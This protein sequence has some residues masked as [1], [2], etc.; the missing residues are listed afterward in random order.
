MGPHDDMHAAIASL[1]FAGLGDVSWEHALDKVLAVTGFTGAALWSLRSVTKFAAGRTIWH[2]LDTSGKDDYIEHYANIDPHVRLLRD[3]IANRIRYD[4]LALPE[5]DMNRHEYY[6]WHEHTSGGLRYRIGG[7]T[8]PGTPYFGSFTLHRPKSRGHATKSEIDRFRL[9]FDH[10]E[11]ALE[12]EYRLD[13]QRGIVAG[14]A[15]AAAADS[16]C[17]GLDHRGQLIF[18]NAMAS[19]L[20]RGAFTLGPEGIAARIGE[21]NR[22][23][24]AL[25]GAC[26][27]VACGAGVRPGGA[28]RLSRPRRSDLFVTVAPVPRDG[29]NPRW[30]GASVLILIVDPNIARAPDEAV[31]RQLFGLTPAEAA[32]AAQLAIGLSLREAASAR[33]IAYSTARSYLE[34]IFHRTGTR[35][36]AELTRV[37]L[38]L[39]KAS[40]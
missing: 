35:R 25:I 28:M 21:Q 1:H 11:R 27:D 3:P 26:L 34:Q 30:L 6:A 39:P 2:R 4:Y 9:L 23:L 10:V 36:Q 31:L 5:S 37:L 32:L 17:V 29:G 8:R 40:G 38:T 22:V 7:A 20:A 15:A 18:A 14:I 13:A 12:V 19:D 24:R 16:G 33:G